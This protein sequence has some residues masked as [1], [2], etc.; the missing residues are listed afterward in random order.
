VPQPSDNNITPNPIRAGAAPTLDIPGA[1]LDQNVLWQPAWVRITDALVKWLRF[2]FSAATRIEHP[3]L[4]DRVWVDDKSASPITIT[5]LAEFDPVAA[6]QRPAILVDRLDQDLDM[7]NRPIGSQL[8]GGAPGQFGHLLVGRHVVH[9]LGGREG[10]AELLAFEVWRDLSRFAPLLRERLCLVR[11]LPNRIGKRVKLSNEEHQQHY[12]V[13]VE[14]MYAYFE[15]W[16][17][18][19]ADEAEVTAIRTAL[20][21]L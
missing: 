1:G 15:Q 16:R 8:Q 5:S 11:L 9:C 6:Q 7:N 19:P 14:V 2:H 4:I 3:S 18:Y 20:S 21:G 10:E 13:P 17:A 12:T